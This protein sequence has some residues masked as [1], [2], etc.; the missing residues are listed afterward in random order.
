MVIVLGQ[1][2]EC[3]IYKLI[4]EFYT[5][6]SDDG[7]FWHGV[8]LDLPTLCKKNITKISIF[9]PSLMTQMSLRLGAF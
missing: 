6:E 8:V 2:Q 3:L 4:L 5:I 7:N 9:L 1:V